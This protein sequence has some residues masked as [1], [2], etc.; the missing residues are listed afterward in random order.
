[1]TEPLARP[2]A[3]RAD[4]IIKTPKPVEDRLLNALG[5]FFLGLLVMASSGFAFLLVTD[6]HTDS[7]TTFITKPLVEVESSP[8]SPP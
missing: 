8:P 2:I 3:P 6:T 1:M 7:L 5:I 4:S